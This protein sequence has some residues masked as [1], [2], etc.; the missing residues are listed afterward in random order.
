[1]ELHKLL[2]IFHLLIKWKFHPSENPRNHFG[3]DK[4]MCM[5]RS[6][7]YIRFKL[8]GPGFGDIVEQCGPP[9]P[10]VVCLQGDVIKYLKGVKKVVFMKQ[11]RSLLPPLSS[12]EVQEK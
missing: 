12:G 9:E 11:S 5:E 6:S 3:P 2:H 7:P 8:P 1:M 4:L 10:Q